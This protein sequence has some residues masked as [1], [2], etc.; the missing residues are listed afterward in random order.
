MH[1]GGS[2]HVSLVPGGAGK[3]GDIGGWGPGRVSGSSAGGGVEVVVQ[4]IMN[5]EIS[6]V[7]NMRFNIRLTF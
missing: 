5:M 3:S 1:S 6:K 4:P 2:W 7:R